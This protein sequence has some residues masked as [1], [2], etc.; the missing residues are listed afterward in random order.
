MFCEN[1]DYSVSVFSIQLR[2]VD[3]VESDARMNYENLQ[4]ACL[5][6]VLRVSLLY[7]AQLFRNV[8]SHHQ[9]TVSCYTL[10]C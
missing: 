1:L 7:T 6:K 9:F 2:I 10:H 5:A 8:S 3:R 4:G